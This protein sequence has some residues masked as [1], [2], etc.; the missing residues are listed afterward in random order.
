MAPKLLRES[1]ESNGLA[2]RNKRGVE[3]MATVFPG[4]ELAHVWNSQ[5][6]PEGRNNNG[7]FY[8]TGRRLYS[9]GSHYL[10]GFI[11]PDG[12]A[13]LNASG[14]SITTSKHMS[15]A[16]GATCNRR[17]I[18]APKLT[19]LDY[20]LRGAAEGKAKR[21]RR[22]VREYLGKHA[23]ELSEEAAAY[24]A[25]VFGLSRSLPA[26]RR[27]AE[28]DAAKAKAEAERRA[29]AAAL[30]DAK[31][32]AEMTAESFALAIPDDD[33]RDVVSGRWINGGLDGF[34][35]R[36]A[37][38]HKAASAAGQTRRKAIL[39]D[40][41][42]AVRAFAKPETGVFGGAERSF[43]TA[44]AI[45]A[46]KERR[47]LER[48]REE[49]ERRQAWLDGKGSG[50]F[51]DANGGALL[52]IIGD[53]GEPE[54]AQLETSHGARVPLNHAIKAFRFVKLIRE[55][56]G[57]WQRN[58]RTVRVGF[59]QLDSIDPDGFNAGCHRINWPEIERVARLAGVFDC[60][61]S[62]AAAEPSASAA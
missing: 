28:R 8:F 19:D 53:P 33:G 40:R 41:L 18:H 13:L 9:Y 39:W 60:P 4:R 1:A 20:A 7:Q 24:I 27:K 3:T 31:R 25:G 21:Y 23:S 16:H 51:S 38:A 52:R 55:T 12:V 46:E 61:A 56:G 15:F 26:I 45:A 43:A 57:H 29:H 49:A 6:Q 36:L 47:R 58:G 2:K 11:M 48:E 44:E 22:E 5:T 34:A 30:A 62:D 14:Y 54:T 50:R 42:K 59:Y 37:R 32:F 17:T 10:A 35:K